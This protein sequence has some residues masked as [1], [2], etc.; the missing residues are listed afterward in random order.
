MSTGISHTHVSLV[1]IV[2]LALILGAAPV[3]QAVPPGDLDLST[4]S[5]SW[6]PAAPT[7]TCGHWNLADD[8]RTWPDHENPNRDSC[9]NSGV[10]HFMRSDSLARNPESYSLLPAF[11]PAADGIWGLNQWHR[12]PLAG[13]GFPLPA[14][15]INATGV[16]QYPHSYI[17]PAGVV[18]LHPYENEMAIVGW[19]AP[20]AGAVSISGTVGDLDPGGNDGVT[21]AIDTQ[22]VELAAGTVSGNSQTFNVSA[23]VQPGDF[24][25]FSISPGPNGDFYSDSTQ[26]D[27]TITPV[28][29]SEPQTLHSMDH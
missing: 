5:N 8:F 15:A 4:G 29:N 28:S 26:L 25:Y 19:Q 21:W 12:L 13:S 16:T 2:A 27:V 20:I 6:E 17:W 14:V 7:M 10:W 11:N 22:S 23:T 18:N 1:I 24:V 3:V 9:G